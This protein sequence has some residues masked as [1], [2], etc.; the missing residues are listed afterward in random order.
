SIFGFRMKIYPI[1][2]SHGFEPFRAFF[3]KSH[4]ERL[5][6][7]DLGVNGT[8]LEATPKSQTTNPLPNI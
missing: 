3:D 4:I 2:K 8:F 5:E 6:T 7:V 1:I